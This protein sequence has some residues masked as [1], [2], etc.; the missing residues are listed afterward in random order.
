MASLEM[1]KAGYFSSNPDQ[2]CQVDAEGLKKLGSQKL[3]TG[4]QVTAENP[5]LG[6]EGRA[7]VL[8][9]LGDALQNKNLFGTTARPGN[10]IGMVVPMIS[11]LRY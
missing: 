11:C 9:R 3:A 4:L 7:G 10:M 6:L 1:F 8:S 2:P 5:I